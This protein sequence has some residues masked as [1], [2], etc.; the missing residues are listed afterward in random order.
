MFP[1]TNPL[2]A[3]LAGGGDPSPAPAPL[4][5][6][7][8]ADAPPLPMAPMGQMPQAPPPVNLSQ[9]HSAADFVRQLAPILIS[10]LAARKDPMLGAAILNGTA[11]GALMARQEQMDAQKRSEDKAQVQRAF[12]QHVLTDVKGL[13]DP[14]AQARYLQ[15]A[16]DVGVRSFGMSPGWSS[17]IPVEKSDG[18]DSLKQEIEKKLVAFDKDPKWKTVAG[19]PQEAKISFRLSNGQSMSITSARRL[20]NQQ[21]TDA[22]GNPT[23]APPPEAKPEKPANKQL[24]EAIVRGR[25]TFLNFDPVSGK[26][27]DPQTGAEVQGAQPITPV[28][29]TQAGGAGTVGGAVQPLKPGERGYKVAQD[30]AYGRLTFQGFRTLYAYSRDASAKE[31]IYETAA[32]LNPDFNQA[33]FERGFK[34]ISN[35]KVGQ[36]LASLDNVLSGVDD[37]IRVS[38]QAARSGATVI[39]KYTTPAKIA[40]GD[41]RFT[42]LKTAQTA[43]ADELSGALGYGSATDMSREMGFNMTDPNLSPENFASALRDIVVPFV[44]RKRA[45]M[46]KQGSVYGKP[47]NN[48]SL[49]TEPTKANRIYYDAN[50]NPIKR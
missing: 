26:M 18:L 49:T 29:A 28:G 33:D 19:T 39:N 14:E 4:P 40:I 36:Q 10:T 13:K 3:L 37:L 43:F 47:E 38:D 1:P 48:S 23:Y 44:Q 9:H 5:S 46:L 15:L 50:G 25:R 35:P 24:K 31:R 32:A 27:T 6:L 20:L 12:V 34:F 22:S 41:R 45:A 11:R 17:Q 21:F 2:F 8:L 16:D 42:N 7:P 30:L